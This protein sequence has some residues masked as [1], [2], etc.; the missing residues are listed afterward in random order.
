MA[1]KRR[2]RQC[3]QQQ[4]RA[5]GEP[6]WCKK[7]DVFSSEATLL[8]FRACRKEEMMPRRNPAMPATAPPQKS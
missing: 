6:G 8:G 1:E 2:S 4:G 5:P 3:E 7:I